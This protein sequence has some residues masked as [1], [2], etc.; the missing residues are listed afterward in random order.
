MLVEPC[1]RQA[2][3]FIPQCRNNTVLYSRPGAKPVATCMSLLMNCPGSDLYSL[4]VL[5]ANAHHLGA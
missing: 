2:A 3:A 1:A 4:T 5:S